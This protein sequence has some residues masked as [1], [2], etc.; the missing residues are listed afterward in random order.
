MW[1]AM[2]FASVLLTYWG[3][4]SAN[5]SGSW[6]TAVKA[7]LLCAGA[8]A[9]SLVLWMVAMGALRGALAYLGLIGLIGMIVSYANRP[10]RAA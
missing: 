5:Q 3:L 1:I 10:R 6:T 7:R 8:I 2:I 9:V 4:N